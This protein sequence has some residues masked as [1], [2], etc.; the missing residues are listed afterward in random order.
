MPSPFVDL[1]RQH[2]QDA[3]PAHFA[4]QTESYSGALE[5]RLL[6]HIP[7][8]PGQRL[9]EIGCGEGGNLFNLRALPVARF[10]V[11]FS[12]A[13]ARFA[14][15]A[16]C[17]HTAVADAARLPF[18]DDS[19]DLVL[20]RD[21]LHHVPDPA[22]V[23][24]EAERVLRRGGRLVVLEPNGRSPLVLLQAALV[25]AERGVL[26]STSAWL[27]EQLRAARLDVVGEDQLWPL[28]IERVLLNPR[29]GLP[30]L[31][32]HPLVQR[33]LGAIDEVAR[34]LLPRAT[35]GYLRFEAVKGAA[36]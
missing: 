12:S 8:E 5:S 26:R 22:G 33:T 29:F 23:V 7:T 17:A 28:P 35:W 34:R 36:Q 32:R 9:L 3:D 6:G 21:V 18:G 20:I 1:Q 25:P 10:G 2:W 27:R 30:A 11:D 13:K 14:R 15:D 16:S 24:A 31:G 4:W 19:F